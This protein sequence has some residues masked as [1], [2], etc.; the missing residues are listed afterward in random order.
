MTAV[1]TD[2]HYRMALAVIRDLGERGVRVVCCERDGGG[3]P[4]GFYSKYCNASRLLPKDGYVDA[5]YGLCGEIARDE[6]EK[7]ALLPVGAATLAELVKPGTAERFAAAAGLLLPEKAA[8]DALNDKE[9]VARLGRELGI[10]VP[11]AYAP[12]AARFPCAVKPRCGERFGLAA[13]Q[14]YKIAKDPEELSAFREHFKSLTGEEPLLQQY[15]PGGGMGCSV[16]AVD[17][18][19]TRCVCHRRIREYPVTGGPSSCAVALRDPVLEGYAA[20]LM[21]RVNFS[22]LAM[23]EFKLDGEGSPFLL[24]VNPRVWGTYPLER[25]ARAGLSWEWF[26]LAWNRGNGHRTLLPDPE[27]LREGRRMT[28]TAS[29][30]A[31]GLGYLKRGQLGRGLG[32]ALDLLN[33]A[34]PDG[35]WEWRDARPALRYYGSLLRRGGE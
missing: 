27:G 34:V 11:E 18:R 1:V 2:V 4:I 31:A 14:R 24:E 17:G 22:G 5:L 20:K 6:G 35:V 19:V 32:A 8:L 13:A 30:L 15:L 16:V 10:P 12:D 33:P 29:D 28:F 25:R 26:R 3:D 21:E 9:T 23:V 7:P